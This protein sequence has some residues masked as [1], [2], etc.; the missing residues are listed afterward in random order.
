MEFSLPQV[1]TFVPDGLALEAALARTTHLAIGAHQDDLEF[2][3]FHGIAEC[4]GR[5]DRWFTG[6]C[7]T[8]GAGSARTGPY[9]YCT[10]EAMQGI[11]VR[12]QRKAAFVGEYSVMLQLMAPSSLVKN[13]SDPRLVEDLV[14]ILSLAQPEF[15]YLHNP[16]DKH[17]THVA[18]CLRA[19]EALRRLPAQAR[20]NCVYG[21]E[22]W[23]DLDWLPDERKQVLSCDAHPNLAAALNGV[24]DS[25]IV[26][27]KRYDLA[28]QGRRAAH[29]TFFESHEV[30]SHT[31]LSFAMDLSPL[32]EQ[33]ELAV[34]DFARGLV[35]ELATDVQARLSRCSK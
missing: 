14:Q 5:T 12:E 18:S 22:I 6:V 4:F 26:G 15:V 19:V 7:M 16:C 13:A 29:A 23:R 9:A 1:E 2:M 17:D 28:I 24:F 20:P 10:D 31:A 25:Q 21:C 27:G 32:L 11:R 8:N 35:E 30:D 34:G 3:A 33:P